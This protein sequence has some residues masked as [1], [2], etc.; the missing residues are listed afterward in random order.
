[1]RRGRDSSRNTRRIELFECFGLDEFLD[2][3]KEEE[4]RA[5]D[6]FG[7]PRAEGAL[8]GNSGLDDP[9]DEDADDGAGEITNA[10][11]EK[12]SADDDRGNGVEFEA[13]GGGGVA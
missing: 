12:A 11:A 8:E 6:D 3:E 4:E 2:E 5:D 7:P 13:G 1:M 9:E 10:A